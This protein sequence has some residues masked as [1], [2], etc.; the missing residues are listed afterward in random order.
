M[1][2]EFAD[3]VIVHSA[4]AWR[5]RADFIITADIGE[6]G[7]LKKWEQLWA[8]RLANSRFELCCIPFFVYDVSLGDE[9]ETAPKGERKFV[10]Q[11]VSKSGG[12][13]TFR[14]W[15]G[16]S[17]EPSAVRDRTMRMVE[18]TASIFE[19][20]STNLLALSATSPK[21]ATLLANF[22]FEEE[23]AHRLKYETGRRS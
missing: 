18:K 8:R 7:S 11:R 20:S 14:V 16:D 1:N 4:P 23:Q 22:L 21:S 9:V 13:A 12:H 10:I 6:S 3:S 15:F 2:D 5:D 19:W 17:S